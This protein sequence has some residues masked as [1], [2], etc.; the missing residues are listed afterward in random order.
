MFEPDDQ[1]YYAERAA[2]AMALGD[3]ATDP[4]VAAVHYELSLRYS[5]RSVQSPQTQPHWLD[6]MLANPDVS[7]QRHRQYALG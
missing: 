5:I 1:K 2:H 6:Y 4:K 7:L 3:Q